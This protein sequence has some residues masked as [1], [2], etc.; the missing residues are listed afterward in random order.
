MMRFM[1]FYPLLFGIVGRY[2]LPAIAETSGFSI[3]ANA[4]FIVVALTMMTPLVFGAV[5]GFSILEDRDDH[6]I[7]SIRVTPLSFNQFMSFRMAIVFCFSFITCIYVMW[8][9]DI[10][11]LS[12]GNI[13]LIA[14]LASFSAPLT[15]LIINV[16]SHNKIEGFAI[17]KLL[18]MLLI[19]PII[20]LFFNDAKELFFAVIPTFWPA[21]MVSS[22]I[23]GG[24]HM[25]ISYYLYFAIGLAYVI[26]MNAYSYVR[27][28]RKVLD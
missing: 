28:V 14:F 5:V 20:S 1:L 13:L 2:I 7:N 24:E 11:N 15:S 10:G 18:G 19:L 21:K 17:M 8:F 9:S 26:I 25:F 23:R 4:D 6:I 27:F 12:W 22:V 3:D 16:L